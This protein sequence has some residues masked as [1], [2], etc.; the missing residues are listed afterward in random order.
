M[1]YCPKCGAQNPEGTNFCNSCG[2]P[3]IQSQ[4]AEG[5]YQKQYEGNNEFATAPAIGFKDAI[6]TCMK[7]KYAS[8]QGRAKRAEF[9]YFCLFECLVSFAAAIVGAI[10]GSLFSGD[11]MMVGI[12]A[13]AIGAYV[14]VILVGL[15][16]ICPGISVIVRRLHDT[17]RSGWW[18][19]ICLVPYVGSIV[20][21]VFELLSSQEHDNEY[22]P[23]VKTGN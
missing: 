6:H 3:L 4:Q 22:G 17:G 14:L 16:F 5:G 20:L 18:Y 21:F 11:D 7:E 8:F 10:I 12:A 9:W 2:A 15:A 13:G 1:S 23:Y 19:W